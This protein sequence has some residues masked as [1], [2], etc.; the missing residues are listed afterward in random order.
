V[1]AEWSLN[2]P[3][4]LGGGGMRERMPGAYSPSPGEGTSGGSR[5]AREQAALG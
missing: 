4:V 1:A 2:F 5:G 3:S